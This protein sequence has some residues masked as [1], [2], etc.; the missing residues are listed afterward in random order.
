M[1]SCVAAA[2]GVGLP[3]KA[4]G[5]RDLPCAAF[6][7]SESPVVSA[8]ASFVCLKEESPRRSP[9]R[10]LIVFFSLSGLV[11]KLRSLTPGSSADQ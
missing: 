9:C 11:A 3:G 4:G 7:A 6:C 10:F 8:A 5:S 1:G 2:I